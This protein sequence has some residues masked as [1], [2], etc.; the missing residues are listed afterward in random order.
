[1]AQIYN[2]KLFNRWCF[3]LGFSR[4][5][6]YLPVPVYKIFDQKF[7]SDFGN[8]RLKFHSVNLLTRKISFDR[9]WQI[10]PNDKC[11]KY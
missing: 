3:S 1:M 7:S 9:L 8:F 6:V 5:S 2:A 4:L 11:A 10:Q